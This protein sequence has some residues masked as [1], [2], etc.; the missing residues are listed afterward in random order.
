MRLDRPIGTWLLL[1]P[2]WWSLALGWKL[3]PEIIELWELGY[4]YLLFSVGAIIMRG[5]GCIINDLWDRKLDKMVARTADRPIASGVIRV[6]YACIFLALLF[7]LAASILFQL[8][9]TCWLLGLFVLILVFTYPVFKRFTY[10]PQ[11]ILGLTFNWGAI[12]GWAA[13]T[14]SVEFPS[15]MLYLLGI[16]WTLGYDTIYAHQDKEDDF[17]IGIKSSALALG[18]Q[19]KLFLTIFY[20]LTIIGIILIGW[21]NQF[22]TIFFFLTLVA[23]AQL[24]WQVTTLDIN[25][26][27][28]CLKKFK[29]NRLFGLI[30]TVAIF[31]G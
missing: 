23:S 18:D 22:G 6:S 31:C 4:L 27:H 2:C 25:L 29:S 5:A 20:S 9:P 14:G 10:W 1:L 8:N 15:L 30:V 12:M 21:L 13:I 26:P 19:T 7:I 24:I 28:N 11:F 3:N 17:M 16:F